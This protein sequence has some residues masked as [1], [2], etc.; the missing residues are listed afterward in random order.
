SSLGVGRERT[1]LAAPS[2]A[3]LRPRRL[4]RD[5]RHLCRDRLRGRAARARARHTRSARRRT[6]GHDPAGPAGGLRRHAGRSRD[7]RRCRIR[8]DP[9]DREPALRRD[10]DGSGDDR[11]GGPAADGRR[12][13]RVRDSRP[14]RRERGPASG[15][16]HRVTDAPAGLP[17]RRTLQFLLNEYCVLPL[18]R[19][20]WARED[21]GGRPFMQ[22][23]KARS[24]AVLKLAAAGLA[25]ALQGA[26]GSGAGTPSVEEHSAF[27]E[28]FCT[29]CHN[30]LDLAADFAF[31]DLDLEN[32]G[33][34]QKLW[35]A[36]VGKLRG[37]LM[38]PAGAPQPAQADVDALVAYL[39]TEIDS[40]VE[41]R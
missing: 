1:L 40:S 18:S 30:P 10:A 4:P 34:D 9:P 17:Y 35:E 15:A 23:S 14:A 3:L 2:R 8:V 25:F 29:D 13:A 37:R 28:T 11:R 12:N 19:G 31:E 6:I 38:P 36:A 41:E 7:R 16:A 32:V 22:K 27:L 21:R 5:R 33:A 39:E 26:C 20:K 24:A